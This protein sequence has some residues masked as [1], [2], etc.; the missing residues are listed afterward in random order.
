[1]GTAVD[2]EPLIVVQS[3][4]IVLQRQN[5]N[6]KVQR[7]RHRQDPIQRD[8]DPRD[9]QQF[10]NGKAQQMSVRPLEFAFAVFLF[11][12]LHETALK[13]Q[14]I[15]GDARNVIATQQPKHLNNHQ[16]E[17]QFLGGTDTL[18]NNH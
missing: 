3:P 9:E 10:A 6:D 15:G 1:M 2:K 4:F 8:G 12:A 14:D 5:G 18:R 17:Y 13:H 11:D 16:E 7:L